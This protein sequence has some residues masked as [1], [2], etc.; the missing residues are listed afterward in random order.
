MVK[1][2]NLFFIQCMFTEYLPCGRLRNKIV[3]RRSPNICTGS[4]YSSKGSHRKNCW[5]CLSKFRCWGL[6]HAQKSGVC[7]CGGQDRESDFV[8]A[9]GDSAAG[10]GRL[11]WLMYCQAMVREG[12]VCYVAS[13]ISDSATL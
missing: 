12:C 4:A 7:R 1:K 5:G 3:N 6:I 9:Q 13:V 2:K 8:C 10:F 11:C